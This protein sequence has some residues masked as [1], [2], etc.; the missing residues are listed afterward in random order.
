MSTIEEVERE[1]AAA[2]AWLAS[3]DKRTGTFRQFWDGMNPHSERIFEIRGSSEGEVRAR[4]QDALNDIGMATDAGGY[5]RESG[6]EL[7]DVIAEAWRRER[8]EA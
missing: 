8:G 2:N 4:A 6:M 5:M 1:W 7:D 3:F